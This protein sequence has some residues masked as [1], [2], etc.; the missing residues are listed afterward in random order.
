MSTSALA[1]IG[2]HGVLNTSLSKELSDVRIDRDLSWLDFNQRVLA[3]QPDKK[4]SNKTL[5]P[6]TLRSQRKVS[7]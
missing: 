5:M 1:S 6:S 2:D 7:S 3:R 4:N